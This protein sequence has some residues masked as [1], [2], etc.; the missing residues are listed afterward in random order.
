MR[1]LRPRR[2]PVA[3]PE[4]AADLRTTLS[5]R[6]AEDQV[7]P[8]ISNGLRLE[9]IFRE[10]TETG[11][12]ATP[13]NPI[14]PF[15]P[16]IGER[17]A[18]VWADE[19]SY[20]LPDRHRLENVARYK[21]VTSLDVVQSKN[22]YLHFLKT[23]LL[24]F[25]EGDDE[26][27]DMVPALEAQIHRLTF[28]DMAV[29]LGYPVYEDEAQDP[30]RQLARLP[31]SVYITTS[32]HD[33]LARML[34]AEGRAPQVQ[35]CEWAKTV[36]EAY[37][38]PANFEPTPERPVVYHLFGLEAEPAS[39]VL[40][41]DDHLDFLIKMAQTIDSDKPVIPLYLAARLAESALM[42]LGYRLYDWD[43]RTLFELLRA[44]ENSLRMNGM[45]IQLDPETEAT[46]QIDGSAA[47][48]YL[49]QYLDPKKYQVSWGDTE[50]VMQQIWE[51]WRTW[52]NR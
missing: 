39:L 31:L 41:E 8:I 23:I 22:D 46:T 44:T 43:F 32:H 16:S 27:T 9:A 38:A 12:E 30:L 6:I 29:E 49:A 24:G 13:A 19:V 26:V 17:L 47:R 42:L 1:Q 18:A 40:S 3:Q 36:P 15:K 5:Q 34:E 51:A 25:A 48:N 11:Q 33:F 4:S 21:R 37:Q 35:I 14:L 28:S 50:S 20:P 10:A 2:R 52:Q 7:I 45:V